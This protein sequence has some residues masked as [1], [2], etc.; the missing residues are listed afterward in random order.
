MLR[1]ITKSAVLPSIL[2]LVSGCAGTAALPEGPSIA[3]TI[4]DE[5]GA[6]VAGAR[7]S[8]FKDLGKKDG[9]DF[10]WLGAE[11]VE[12]QAAKEGRA[13]RILPDVP[14]G[15]T[16]VEL[17]LPRT[18][19][20]EGLAVDGAGAPIA[21]YRVR[22]EPVSVD[23]TYVRPRARW[24]AV[25]GAEVQPPGRFQVKDLPPGVYSVIVRAE[26]YREAQTEDITVEA[27]KT[28]RA[29]TVTLLPAEKEAD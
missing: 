16:D 3:G 11:P 18:G 12:I 15:T 24:L 14:P 8:A 1:R 10:D 7:V 4:L 23:A 29:G 9:A 6:P 5:A 21:S 22:A 25:P 26:T 2:F 27:G 28:S 17:V 20:I 19:A 13:G